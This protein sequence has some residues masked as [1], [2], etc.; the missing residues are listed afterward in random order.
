MRISSP[1]SNLLLFLIALIAAPAVQ[2]QERPGDA[3]V[4]VCAILRPRNGQDAELR[5]S[6]LVL[7]APTRS[8]P[9]NIAYQVHAT[10]DGTLFLFEAWRSQAD[11]D[12]HLRKPAVVD[13]VGRMNGLLEGGNEAHFGR[14]ISSAHRPQSQIQGGDPS[15]SVHI[16]SIKRPRPGQAEALRNALLSLRE[17]TQAEAGHI[18]YNLYGEENGT[19][20]LYEAWR[21]QAD[22]EQ[23][24]RTPYVQAFRQQVDRLAEDN[25]VYI[26]K[27]ISGDGKTDRERPRGLHDIRYGSRRASLKRSH[28]FQ[29]RGR[30]GRH[31]CRPSR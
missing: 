3:T 29:P 17:P 23:H 7:V 22:L 31:G 9:G 1:I 13:F 30:R 15:A 26:G 5:R 11:L 8:E 6:L 27:P 16:C 4:N 24:F 18:T 19:L 25:R 20:F 10:A 2:A 21:S 12:L 28:S 14:V